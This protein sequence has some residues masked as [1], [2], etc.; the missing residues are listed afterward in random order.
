MFSFIIG[1]LTSKTFIISC[2][3][4]VLCFEF[5]YA[6]IRPIRN[7]SAKERDIDAKYPEF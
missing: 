6:K 4:G 7:R 5:A 2:I 3:L 1:I